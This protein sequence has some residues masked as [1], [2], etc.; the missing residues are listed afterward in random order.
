M[1]IGA[2]AAA[3]A[4]IKQDAKAGKSKIKS[5]FLMRMAVLFLLL[6]ALTKGNLC[7]PFALVI[8]FL[9]VRPTIT[10]TEFFRKSGDKDS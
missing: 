2:N 9:F 3:D 8:P 7:N 1:A 4:A 6:F 5:S 10:V